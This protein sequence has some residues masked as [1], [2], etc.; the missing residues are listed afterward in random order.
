MMR[1]HGQWIH[2]LTDAE[3]RKKETK[4]GFAL[5]F[6]TFVKRRTNAANITEAF[7][8]GWLRAVLGIHRN[9][10]V[11]LDETTRETLKSGG[12]A[13]AKMRL[14]KQD[15]LFIALWHLNDSI[16]RTNFK[17]A[18]TVWC[19][20]RNVDTDPAVQMEFIELLISRFEVSKSAMTAERVSYIIAAFNVFKA[21]EA[22]LIT[23]EGDKYK[24]PQESKDAPPVPHPKIAELMKCIR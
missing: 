21:I 4:T 13:G 15:L 19:F 8:K 18:G 1:L 20:L 14:A 11:R 22:F 12:L 6:A 3:R 5:D 24:I 7:A 17:P 16:H 2:G 10:I 9:V 23:S